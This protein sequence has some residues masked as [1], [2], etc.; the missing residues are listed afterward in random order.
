MNIFLDVFC[1]SSFLSFIVLSL[2]Y[3][4][5][6]MW[7]YGSFHDP[8]TNSQILTILFSV[9]LSLAH[10]LTLA[11]PTKCVTSNY[12]WSEKY[13]RANQQQHQYEL[14]AD[15]HNS[16]LHWSHN[17]RVYGTEK[18]ATAQKKMKI[19]MP[20]RRLRRKRENQTI[21]FI[22][23][24]ISFFSLSHFISLSL[25]VSFWIFMNFIFIFCFSLLHSTH[26]LALSLNWSVH[27]SRIESIKI[28]NV[29]RRIPILSTEKKKKICPFKFIW[30]RTD[31]Y[32]INNNTVRIQRRRWAIVACAQPERMN[33][34]SET[35]VTCNNE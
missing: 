18:G 3:S 19:K 34:P 4:L 20:E 2:S 29:H 33:R 8:H 13:M 21:Y 22:I 1:F 10:S 24:F 26:I 15:N 32:N 16:S 25:R 5:D 35:H 7:S 23:C 12:I 6:W 30:Q 14:Y 28:E 9:Y 11:D 17:I 31:I 27:S